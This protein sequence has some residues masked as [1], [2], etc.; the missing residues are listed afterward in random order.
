MP[1]TMDSKQVCKRFN[2]IDWH[3]S[4]LRSVFVNY[5][6][7]EP[8]SEHSYEIILTVDL[9]TFP[10]PRETEVFVPIEVRFLRA[11]YFCADLDLLGMGYCGGDISG[12]EC[13]EESNFKRQIFETKIANFN[14]PQDPNSWANL[15][16]FQI[17]LCNPSGDINIIAEDFRTQTFPP[18]S[19]T[20]GRTVKLL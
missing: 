5:S 15:K 10:S 6:R 16:H 20:D 14:L 18:S 2:E 3:D 9:S 1:H 7:T 11:R 12:A 17:Y 8:G 19:S 4:E 13:S